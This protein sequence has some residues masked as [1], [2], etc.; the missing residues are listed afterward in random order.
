MLNATTYWAKEES[1]VVRVGEVP[2]TEAPPP[3]TDGAM[4]FAAQPSVLMTT[5]VFLLCAVLIR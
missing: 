3:T 5:L 4:D 2:V 1:A